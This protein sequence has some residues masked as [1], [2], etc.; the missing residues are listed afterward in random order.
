MLHRRC[1]L[2]MLPLVLLA[3]RAG[4]AETPCCGPITPAGERLA[5]TLDQMDVSD[6]WL[7]HQSVKWRTGE[8][9]TGHGRPPENQTHCSAFVAAAADRLGIYILRPPQHGQNLLANAQGA[10]LRGPAGV[11]SGWRPVA[12]AQ[13]AQ[14]LANQGALVVGSYQQ[15]DPHKPGHIVIVRPSLKDQASLDADGPD[16]TQAGVHNYRLTSLRIGFR[17][18]PQAFPNGI[19]FYAHQLG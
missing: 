1:L 8:P 2:P 4:W 3:A 7:A 13:E 17:H 6:K 15:P 10:W 18:H 9:W 5:Q 12:T 16:I 14:T 19:R 11:A